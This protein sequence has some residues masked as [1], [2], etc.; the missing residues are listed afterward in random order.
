MTIAKRR[1]LA[2]GSIFIQ[3]FL[4][5]IAVIVLV[6]AAN[7][8][9]SNYISPNRDPHFPVMLK[10]TDFRIELVASNLSLPTS[11]AFLDHRNILVIEKNTG[12]VRLISDDKLRTKSLLRLNVS[13]QGERGLLGLAILNNSNSN[14]NT[15]SK[16]IDSEKDIKGRYSF[17]SSLSP[18]RLPN[19]VT[20]AYVFFY[21]TELEKKSEARNVIY[22]YEWNGTALVNSKKIL[23]SPAVAGI[24]HN[25]GKMIIGPRDHQLYVTIGD[26]NS[27]NTLMQ[28]YKY[29]KKSSYSSVI[30]RI[31]PLTGLPSAGN[32]F[33]NNKTTGSG[34]MNIT[35]LDYLYAYG[36]R[37]SF[38]LAF[39]TLTG[40]LWDTENGEN[41]YDEVNLVKPGFNSGWDKIMGPFARNNDTVAQNKLVN[42]PGSYYSDPKFS[43]RTPLGV[44]A[45][46]FF[47][48]FKFGIKYDN[49]I[50]IGDI[51]FG[52][53]YNFKVNNPDRTSLNLN[54]GPHSGLVDQVADNKNESVENLFATNFQ[55]RITDIKTGPDGN[56]YILTYFDGKIYKIIP[57]N[58][59]AI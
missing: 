36:V 27:P 28:N 20:K 11:M 46:E 1:N 43:W 42:L 44:T 56:L 29:G 25:G 15:T 2:R 39:D 13:S 45:I 6:A 30:L 55:G 58:N 38:G 40:S 16:S 49:S 22:R 50:F 26:L 18:K 3:I 12:D 37:N 53:I 21:V 59:S 5:V 8:I 31:D 24:F 51:N 33:L 7:L 41:T 9:V 57:K 54:D 23:D 4:A 32:P 35:G 48:S 34:V 10:N 14:S 17:A 19:S 52:N 47:N